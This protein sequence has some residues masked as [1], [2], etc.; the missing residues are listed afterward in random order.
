[1]AVTDKTKKVID[2]ELT[3][4]K[5]ERAKLDEAIK[6]LDAALSAVSSSTVGRVTRKR[7]TAARKPQRAS[8]KASSAS[9]DWKPTGRAKQALTQIKKNPGIT[10]A[11][12]AKK[13]KLKNSTAIYPAIN[14]LKDNKFIAKDGKGYRAVS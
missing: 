14:K 5:A 1:M 11:E 13:L 8:K 3:R 10:A 2:L 4:L 7:K 9:K 6:R 12:V